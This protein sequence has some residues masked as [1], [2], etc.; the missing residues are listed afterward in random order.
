MSVPILYYAKANQSDGD[1]LP[2]LEAELRAVQAELISLRKFG[3]LQFELSNQTSPDD[4]RDFVRHFKEQIR[5]LHFTG[6]SGPN[7]LSLDGKLLPVTA[8]Q[9]LLEGVTK[10][11]LVFLNGCSN[12]KMVQ[13]LL[14]AGVKSVIATTSKVYDDDAARLSREFYRSWAVEGKTLKDAYREAIAFRVGGGSTTA[15]FRDL[16]SADPDAVADMPWGLYVN[17][18]AAEVLDAVLHVRSEAAA[19]VVPPS[20]QADLDALAKVSDKIRRLEAADLGDMVSEKVVERD[21]IVARL[22]GLERKINLKNGSLRLN[23]TN[24]LVGFD[25]LKKHQVAAFVLR[26]QQGDGV[27]ILAQRIRSDLYKKYETSQQIS[28]IDLA[29]RATQRLDLARV[30]LEVGLRIGSGATPAEVLA[31]LEALLDGPNP[32]HVVLLFNN[33]DGADSGLL[34]E[35]LSSFWLVVC[36]S[37][38]DKTLQRKLVVFLLDRMSAED[39]DGLPITQDY[40][41]MLPDAES[42]HLFVFE[43]VS[44]LTDA[45]FQQWCYDNGD[46]IGD[47]RTVWADMLKNG[48]GRVKPTINEV[49]RRAEMPDLCDEFDQWDNLIH[50]I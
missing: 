7:A 48:G 9:A 2:S 43:P 10:L 13:N 1:F 30:W 5:V 26:G 24:Q 32:Q 17:R 11:D 15:I 40:A 29:N 20:V 22:E 31:R 4:F 33:V 6:H 12:V 49:F 35:L 46:A 8:L 36:N 14:D 18:A 25:A 23:Y 34:R 39:K 27:G 47:L 21:K 42:A 19:A 28:Q 44:A 16:M 37:L 50:L 41:A 3:K 38:K 45:G